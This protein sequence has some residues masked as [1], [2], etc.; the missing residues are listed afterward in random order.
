MPQV[1]LVTA[2][3]LSLLLGAVALTQSP[4]LPYHSLYADHHWFVLQDALAAR[5]HRRSIAVRWRRPSIDRL[6]PNGR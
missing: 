2:A 1:R 6:R 4:L 5:R 3:I